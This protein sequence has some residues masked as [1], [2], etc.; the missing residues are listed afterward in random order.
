M[1]HIRVE[2]RRDGVEVAQASGV[3][4]VED[5]LHGCVAHR[6]LL[7]CGGRFEVD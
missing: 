2:T 4:M 6:H 3:E 5:R 1:D 7:S